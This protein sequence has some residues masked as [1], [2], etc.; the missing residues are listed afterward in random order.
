MKR[1]LMIFGFV[2]LSVS[3]VA[4]F[5]GGILWISAGILL[6]AFLLSLI[7]SPL[8]RKRI[9]PVI[10]ASCLT[11]VTAVSLYTEL[12]IRPVEIMQG[13]EAEITAELCELPY[14]SSGRYYYELQAKELI[15]ED[16][17]VT[18]DVRL[19]ISSEQDL[20]IAPCD[21]LKAK[22]KISQKTPVYR[23][24]KGVM[25][26]GYLTDPESAE[27]VPAQRHTVY[28]YF[29]QLR[30]SLTE[31]IFRCMTPSQSGFI[32]AFLLGEKTLVSPQIQEDL[33]SAGL[34]HIV[35]VSGLH[36]A[37]LTQLCMSVMMLTRKRRAAVL[38]S[39]GFVLCY[40]TLT[41]FSPSV[42]RAG[43]MQ[44]MLL[45]GRFFFK[46][47]DPLTSLSLSV[48]II[49]A[50]NP[51]AAADIS[52]LLSFSA[53][54]GILLLSG[55]LSGAIKKHI[56]QSKKRDDHHKINSFIQRAFYASAEVLGVSISAYLFVMPITILYF[57]RIP[58]YGVFVN[59]LIAPLLTILMLSSVMMLLL[60]FAGSLSFL[61]TPFAYAAGGM[62][63][64]IMAAAYQTASLP[65]AV[66]RMSEW[67][68]PWWLAGIML[69]TAVLT[70]RKKLWKRAGIL[71]LTGILSLTG[72]AAIT[73][74]MNTRVIRL[75]VLNT[76]SGLSVVMLRE[77]KA[78][79]LSCGGD[80]TAMQ[81][82][83]DYLQGTQTEQIS[84]LLLNDHTNKAS[85]YAENLLNTFP[86][87]T[88]VVFQKEKWREG[89]VQALEN[90]A[91][92]V[93]LKAEKTPQKIQYG[94]VTIEAMGTWG[95][96]AVRAEVQGYRILVCQNDTDVKKLP[97]SW[98][99]GDILIFNG[100]LENLQQWQYDR[101]IISD[102]AE[103]EKTYR[104]W[105]QNTPLYTY[106][107]GSVIVRLLQGHQTEIR[108]EERWLS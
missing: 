55:R 20:A 63:E 26:T 17:T 48:L 106:D 69:A 60:S 32:A 58:L 8:R 9:V 85:L 108:R 103:N 67:Y 1:P 87:D 46:R 98:K 33:R 27:I 91:N 47:G 65:F 56:G 50:V 96:H 43:V 68:V 71:L 19:L 21:V 94:D 18:K 53:T 5:C 97:S 30:K 14:S 41:G 104:Y 95:C 10:L 6:T 45:C 101:I 51:Y 105:Q 75:A 100:R 77:H 59:L 37:I 3:A 34:S 90:A 102:K 35:V 72:C 36:L 57:Q 15:A 86:T 16:K 22:V 7:I 70:F 64:F 25:L 29:Q 73:D 28:Y 12:M 79:V 81:T 88:A 13:K 24:V 66:I 38:V 23:Q 54:L 74:I 83:G 49:C 62:T 93:D 11:A 42:V 44:L 107:G 80:Y 2:F 39:A 92:C 31:R 78:V 82:V 4:V 76:G 89:V 84:V 40:M 99:S 61:A 52:L